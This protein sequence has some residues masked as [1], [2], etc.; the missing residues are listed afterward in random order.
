MKHEHREKLI[1]VRLKPTEKARIEEL[2]AV[3]NCLKVS[4]SESRCSSN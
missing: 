2:S 1:A 4:L 3:M